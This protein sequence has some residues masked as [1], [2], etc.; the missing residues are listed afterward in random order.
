MS[1]FCLISTFLCIYR[2]DGPSS[3]FEVY[4][5]TSKTINVEV[6]IIAVGIKRFKVLSQQNDGQGFGG[7]NSTKRK[8]SEYAEYVKIS[9]EDGTV[10]FELRGEDLDAAF[11][12]VEETASSID[13][14]L[15]VN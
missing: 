10:L 11:K 13:Y 7:F 2:G 8:P 15:E 3:W 14:R 4:N 5:H 9:K 12:V 1:I 6:E